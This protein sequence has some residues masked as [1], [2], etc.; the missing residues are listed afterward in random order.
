MSNS[1]LYHTQSIR[2]YQHESSEYGNGRVI[3]NIRR[4][5]FCCFKCNSPKVSVCVVKERL[6]KAEKLGNKLL[7]VRVP[8]HRVYCCDCKSTTIEKISF[9]SAPKARITRSL[10][11]TIIEPRSEMI[12]SAIAEFFDL[13]WRRV[14][15][16]EKKHLEKKF[17]YIPL[18]D[19]K[20]I[21]MDELYVK[22]QGREKYITI[23]RDLESGSV[24]STLEMGKGPTLL[25]YLAENL[26][27]QKQR[28]LY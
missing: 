10:E 5:F 23:V 1:L 17:K 26:S 12:I 16:C 9:L 11:R 14:K 19:V 7:S 21:W 3:F 15:D 4:K 25:R 6:I 2:D 13:D 24:C 28:Y 18:K 8:V 20:V 27:I 22:A